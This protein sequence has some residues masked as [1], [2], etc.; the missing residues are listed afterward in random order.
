MNQ[1]FSCQT[2]KNQSLLETLHSKQEIKVPIAVVKIKLHYYLHVNVLAPVII[3]HVTL[4]QV[5]ILSIY[6]S[7]HFASR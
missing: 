7:C 6:L 3:I 5:T 4:Y 1:V 2:K